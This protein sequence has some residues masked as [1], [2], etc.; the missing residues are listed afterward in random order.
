MLLLSTFDSTSHPT[1][2]NKNDESQVCETNIDAWGD[3]YV[4]PHNMGMQFSIKP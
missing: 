2:Q 4:K 3:G 1:I